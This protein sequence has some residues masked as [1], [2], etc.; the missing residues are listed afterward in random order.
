MSI[1]DNWKRWKEFLGDRVEQAENLGMSE[2][3][4]ASFAKTVGDYLSE[5]VDPK[6]DQDRVLKDL[7]TVAGEPE[8]LVLARLIMK[9]VTSDSVSAH[10]SL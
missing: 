5:H 3:T 8:R 1:M 7:W 2:D 6:N 4:V 10:Q 9:M